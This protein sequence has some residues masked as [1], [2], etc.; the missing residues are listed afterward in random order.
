MPRVGRALTAEQ[1][2][3][4]NARMRA[5]YARIAAESGHADAVR[6]VAAR[7]G[8]NPNTIRKLVKEN[9]A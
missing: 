5:V 7:F 2:E 3:E 9:D 1:R 8:A 4:R 6:S